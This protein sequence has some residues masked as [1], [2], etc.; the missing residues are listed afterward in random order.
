MHG[1]C[2]SISTQYAVGSQEK[3]LRTPREPA[4]GQYG[5]P[6]LRNFPRD[7]SGLRTR[8]GSI[9]SMMLPVFP[10][11]LDRCPFP[12]VLLRSEVVAAGLAL[13]IYRRAPALR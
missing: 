12:A 10:D 2:E 6:T 8:S 11:L 1:A 13:P 7:H 4:I 9:D 5:V 3:W